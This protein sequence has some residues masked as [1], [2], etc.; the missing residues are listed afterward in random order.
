VKRSCDSIACERFEKNSHFHF[1]L[2]TLYLLFFPSGGKESGLK[3][4][5]PDRDGLRN[6]RDPC[7]KVII[8]DKKCCRSHTPVEFASVV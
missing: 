1:I 2:S 4:A 8:D 3:S 5:I 7:Q 6:T